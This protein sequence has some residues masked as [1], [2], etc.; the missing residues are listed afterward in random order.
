MKGLLFVASLLLII[1]CG[2]SKEIV[3]YKYTQS[4]MMGRMTIAVTQDSIIKSYTG[5]G[6][7]SRNAFVTPEQTWTDLN[8]GM[9]KVELK[10]LGNL[11]SPTNKRQT[12]Q[13]PYGRLYFT[14]KDSTYQSLDFDGTDAHSDFKD[15]MKVFEELL[16]LR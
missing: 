15:I 5:R 10:N 1:S 9:E 4:S 14:T 12:D 16:Q 11:K 6:T 3:E 7:P 2:S 13:A 8:K